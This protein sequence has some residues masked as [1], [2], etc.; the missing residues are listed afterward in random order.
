V[1][2]YASLENNVHVGVSPNMS[3]Y[4]PRNFLKTITA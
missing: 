3:R 1:R 4:K 2:K